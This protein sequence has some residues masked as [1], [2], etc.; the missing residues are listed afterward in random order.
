[1]GTIN[2]KTSDYITLGLKPLDADEYK[3][4]SDFMNFIQEEWG[5]DITNENVVESAI[6]EQ[7][8]VDYQCIREEIEKVL[9]NYDFY[10]YNVSIKSGYYEG[11]SIDIENNISIFNDYAEKMEA[12]KEITQIKKCLLECAKMGLVQ[13]FPGWCTGYNDYNGTVKSIKDA[14]KAMRSEI[15][16]T[17]TWN[18]YKEY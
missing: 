1:M 18:S 15:K 13:C 11:F 16:S 7:I 12:N 10:Y 14:I 17:P 8:E 4:D 9:D 6:E 5:V 2:Y 3:N